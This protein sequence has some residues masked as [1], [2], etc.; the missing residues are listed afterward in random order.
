M[1]HRFI[2]DGMVRHARPP[3][4]PFNMSPECDDFFEFYFGRSQPAQQASVQA[5]SITTRLLEYLEAQQRETGPVGV[6]CAAMH[7]AMPKKSVQ[8]KPGDLTARAKPL[9][10]EPKTL[11][12]IVRDFG[13][14]AKAKLSNVAVHGQPEDQLKTP[15][16]TLLKDLGALTMPL[17]KVGVVNETPLPEMKTR[18]DFSITLDSALVGHIELKAPGKGADPRRFRDKHDKEQWSH[19][20]S[21]PNLI[22]TDG[23]AFSLWR[24]GELVGAIVA[25][26]GDIE[27]A[28]AD[29]KAPD[30]LEQLIVDFFGWHPIPPQD[31]RQLAESSARLCRLLRDEV[32]EHLQRATS[33][34]LVRLKADW[35]K[36][37][38]SEVTDVEFADGYAQTVTFGMLVAR[39][40]GIDLMQGVDRAGQELG[41]TVIGAALR[42]LTFGGTKELRT[43]HILQRVLGAVHW[44]KIGKDNPDAWLYFYE[45]FLSVYDNDLRK[46]TG[47]YYTPAPVVT[48][49]VRLVDELLQSR[50]DLPEGLAAKTVTIADPAVGT[51]TFL[52]GV[53]RRIAATV[54]ADEGTG[55]VA[56]A[57]DDAVRRLVAFEIQLGPFAVAQL[58]VLAELRF[59]IKREPSTTPRMFVTDTLAN[60]Y[61]EQENLGFFYETLAESRRQ[62]N[63]VKRQERVM[64]VIG[65]PPYKEKAKGKGGWIEDGGGS[66]DGSLPAVPPLDAWIPPKDWGVGAHV[67]HLRN[68]YVYFWRWATWKVFDQNP[69]ENSGI[70]CFISGSGY[71]DGP[72]FQRMRDYLRRTTDEI[73]VIDCS[74]EGHQPEVSTRVFEGMQQPVCIVLAVRSP[75]TDMSRPAKVRYRA[76]PEGS[77]TEKFEALAGIALDDQRWSECSSGWRDSFLPASTGAWSTFPFL[78]DIFVYNGSGV[79]PKRTWVI[80]PDAGSLLGRWNAL[81]EAPQDKKEYLFHATLRKGEPADRHIRSVV[82]EGLP[83]FKHNATPLY[84]EL[85]TCGPP[86]RFGY[87]SFDRQWIIPDTRVITQP[88]RELWECYSERQVYITAG[89]RSPC[90]G[91]ALTLSGDLPDLN[92]YKGSGGGRVYPL[93]LDHDCTSPNIYPGLIANLTTRYGG[94]VSAEDVFAYL[95]AV[96]SH[97][98]FIDRF[99]EDLIRP[100]LR[101]P[102]TAIAPLFR[103]AVTIG[104]TVIWLH[105]Y[106]ERFVDPK[107]NRPKRS[108]RLPE[109]TRPKIPEQG[110]ISSAPGEMPDELRYEPTEKR[111]YVGTGF[112]ENVTPAMWAYEVA[113]MRVIVHWFSYRKAN[114]ERPMIGD[115]RPPSPL[116]DI[117]PDH[118][119]AEYTTDLLDLLNVLGLLVELEPKQ[120]NLLDRIC[121]GAIIPVTELKEAGA[122]DLDGLPTKPSAVHHTSAQGSLHWDT[123]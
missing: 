95:V 123:E 118:W 48:N 117:Q 119:L 82:T 8:S 108:P 37:F 94:V 114:R 64:V 70:V 5:S 30:G 23:N 105:T 102:I 61:I 89:D 120:A 20:K 38:I 69:T 87:R 63:H 34:Q 113:G 19:L 76:L 74:P 40:Q 18:P 14:T 39:A 93:W 72:G 58:R 66:L 26:D 79:Q 27:T 25:L 35:A 83:R 53:L 122:F 60:P 12:T 99:R 71:L 15:V 115:R 28:G 46:Q 86:V 62:A 13:I 32:E 36:I 6:A 112:V 44:K 56:G 116:G 11:A 24:N 49:M 47:S 17:A 107:E 103:E 57:I 10:R 68:M 31:A 91:P 55:A 90:N 4:G 78:S 110:V 80:A 52:L 16:E 54:E 81:V 106:G 22:Y 88:N 41:P 111:L 109:A 98:G 92:R 97:P 59:L 77:R 7:T 3:R 50:F 45:D 96:T 1:A 43:V 101:V 67:K 84:N 100:E 104:C 29:L 51:G 85:N 21:L 42:A 9:Q 121:S 75:N 2:D 73:W 65:N 33:G